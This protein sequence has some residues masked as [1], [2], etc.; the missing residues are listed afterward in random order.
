[1]SRNPTIHPGTNQTVT[2]QVKTLKEFY[3]KTPLCLRSRLR[4]VHECKIH[5][6]LYLRQYNSL[7]Q[8]EKNFMMFQQGMR[9]EMGK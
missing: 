6:F 9:K 2:N 8:M 4:L 5:F 1:M 7:K 3:C